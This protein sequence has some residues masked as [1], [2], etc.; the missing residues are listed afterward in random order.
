M[1][2]ADGVEV[3]RAETV[4]PLLIADTGDARLRFTTTIPGA[5]LS[6]S[7]FGLP[8][9]FEL[10]LEVGCGAERVRSPGF[11]MEYVPTTA[12]IAPPVQPR[13]FWASDV[14]GDLL[15][16]QGSDLVLVSAGT[17]ESG[18][19]A[20]GFPCAEAELKGELGGRRYLVADEAGVAAIDPGP[21]LGW[22]RPL[23]LDAVWTDAERDP[24]VHWQ[25]G[26]ADVVMVLDF[27]SGADAVG[28]L[29]VTHRPRAIARNAANEILVLGSQ[30]DLA[31]PSLTYVVER[32][33]ESGAGLGSVLAAHYAWAAPSYLA[34]FSFDGAGLFVTAAPTG[35]GQRWIERVDPLTG[36][37]VALTTSSAPWR[38]ALGEAWGRLLVASDTQLVW[39][40]PRTGAALSAAFAPDSGNGFLR[41]RVEPDGS[42]IMLADATG[43][44][45]Q[46]L[47]VFA[48]DGATVMR[49]TSPAAVFR[50]LTTD[51]LGGSLIGYFDEVHAL[52]TRAELTEALQ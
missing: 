3:A 29:P 42:V 28:P 4:E 17:T 20:L 16:C 14:P 23:P 47:Y 26:G 33:D 46:G 43:P 5:E 2:Y 1:A 8:A 24:V 9:R 40:D 38:F 18:R 45:A 30:R 13:R 50:W 37:R 7:R 39:L 34:E 52:P 31:A 36:E 44:M 6:P 51:W 41:L 48:P 12:A 22:S 21:A 25:A 11:A 10:R 35:E 49:F 27:A 32:F 19:F 15:V